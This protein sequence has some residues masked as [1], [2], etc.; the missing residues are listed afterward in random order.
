MKPVDS[1]HSGIKQ[2][3]FGKGRFLIGEKLEGMLALENVY[4]EPIADAG[5]NFI[6]RAHKQGYYY[7]LSNL[8][9]Q[10]L[11]G[12]I[13]LGVKAKSAVIFDPLS[14]RRG[15]AKMQEGE[16]G[17]AQVYL[18]LQ[19]GESCILQTF[20]TKKI[21]GTEWKY[22]NVSGK[23][24][25]ITGEWNVTFI[26]GAPELPSAFKT[27]QLTSWTEFGGST[28]KNF[29]GTAKYS[30]T[31]DK[32]EQQ[33]DDWLLDLGRVCESAS[34]TVNGK[35]MGVLFSLP[36]QINV[37]EA[38]RDGQNTLEIE[39]TNLGANR[40]AELDRQKVPWKKFYNIN[41]VNIKYK[42]FDAS[43]WQ[44]MDSGLIGPVLLIPCSY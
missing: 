13:T 7:F 2:A 22:L 10:A 34:V 9:S 4:R 41:Y 32:P 28:T 3:N 24:F 19:P 17:A 16:A 38:L 18:Q 39:V 37:G 1:E 30:I 42:P 15:I 21:I 20:S 27:E 29:S 8:G 14:A 36:F 33:A 5:I 11:D 6:R 35:F 26:E 25:E 44:P 23:P 12:W 43:N 40:I 31:F